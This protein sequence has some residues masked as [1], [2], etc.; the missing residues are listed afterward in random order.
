MSTTLPSDATKANSDSS[1]DDP[2]QAIL[3]DLVGVVDKFNL[4]LDAL[5]GLAQLQIGNGL[6]T[7]SQS[8]GTAD[9]LHANLPYLAK[10]TAYT[11][12]A[13][14]RGKLIDCTSGTFSLTMTAAATLADGWYCYVRNS[15]SGVIT[16]DPNA[17]E[18]V[19]G[20][21][22]ITLGQGDSLVIQC[23][24]S[25]F[26]TIGFGAGKSKVSS[27][28]TTPGYLNG[29]LVAGTGITLTEG[30]GGSNETLTV[31]CTVTGLSAAS[32]GQS[33]LKTTTGEVSGSA[34]LTLPGGSYGFYPQ[35][36]WNGVGSFPELT[37]S[38]AGNVTNT[39]T[40]AAFV[41]LS[42]DGTGG[43]IQYASQRYATASPPYN[44]GNGDI[45]L[46]V[47]GVIDSTTK[48][49]LMTY[50]AQDPPWAYNG[51]TDIRPDYIDP[52]TGKKY[53]R[54]KDFSGIPVSFR[55]KK[56]REIPFAQRDAYALAIK[57]AP[58]VLVE[59]D[60]SLKNFD[61]PLIPHPFL[62]NNLTGKTIVLL[63]PVGAMLERLYNL[64]DQGE[65]V[66]ELLHGGYLYIDNVPLVGVSL[67]PGV[68][69]HKVNWK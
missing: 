61:M 59:I 44:L 1:A 5:G 46:F 62:G 11:V 55:N 67:P 37:A 27:D 29:K 50:V 47:F 15:G 2:K 60:Q 25:A 4:L 38:F 40:A 64:H 51:P 57:N 58:D 3:T 41:N 20:A 31:A 21:S 43:G 10:T 30:S 7:E 33:Q 68:A 35:F 12:L 6:T 19:D 32:V 36:R 13:A 28:D 23:S 56:T 39:T 9:K 42:Y 8:A 24:G 18:L 65:S 52:V 26:K 17:S 69:A 48:Q 34:N 54:R 63:D 22:T 66:G 16:I 49:V 14:D 53:K 45:P